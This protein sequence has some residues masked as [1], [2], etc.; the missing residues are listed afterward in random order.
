MRY[1]LCQ[2]LVWFGLV[3][4]IIPS[5]P[6]MAADTG[7]Q[8]SPLGIEF[9]KAGATSV[10]TL[11][12]RRDKPALIQVQVFKWTQ[13]DGVDVYEATQDILISPPVFTIAADT[14][15]LVRIGFRKKPDPEKQLTYRL[16]VREI[17]D[18]TSPEPP[19]GTVR[20]MV[21]FSLPIFVKPAAQE[22]VQ[23]AWASELI[24]PERRLRIELKNQGNRHIKIGRFQ[25]K[26]AT[27]QLVAEMTQMTYVLQQQTG[28]W[29]LPMAIPPASGSLNLIAE[30]DD[31]EL[32]ADL[33]LEQN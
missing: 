16:S 18:L 7:L 11:K 17:P 20:V 2:A 14:E 4:P 27:G 32:R 33:H 6:A 23:M 22:L 12:N 9:D 3:L 29:T 1:I 13:Q 26:D 19:A 31:G 28:E 30:T 8:I 10:V 5:H 24:G 21:G 25:V 15:Q